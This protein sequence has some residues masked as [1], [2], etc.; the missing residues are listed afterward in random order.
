MS[1]ERERFEELKARANGLG[2]DLEH[3]DDK[4]TW[5]YLFRP[6]DQAIVNLC[7]NS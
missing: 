4:P 6:F 2:W 3:K 5:G 7:T 1:D